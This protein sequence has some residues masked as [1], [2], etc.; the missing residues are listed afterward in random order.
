MKYRILACA[1]V[2]TGVA[3]AEWLSSRS[4]AAQGQ[5]AAGA[6]AK[7]A[8]ARTAWGDPDLQG[9]W[10]VAETGTPMERPNEFGNRE[11]SRL[12]D[13]NLGEVITSRRSVK[14][15]EEPGEKFAV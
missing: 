8:V 9:K 6:A 15:H 10:A 5:A 12:L 7:G 1:I 11:L 14:L 3:Q 2:I 4:V 13:N